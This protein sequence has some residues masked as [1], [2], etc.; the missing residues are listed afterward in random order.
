MRGKMNGYIDS[1]ALW[2]FVIAFGIAGFESG[3]RYEGIAGGLIG[4]ILIP[5]MACILVGILIFLVWRL[6][7]PE[8]RE[9]E[10]EAQARHDIKKWEKRNGKYY[11]E[12]PDDKPRFL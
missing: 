6:S 7:T 11:V 10:R 5:L 8:G 2:L 1:A 4:M 3:Y 12:W 9:A